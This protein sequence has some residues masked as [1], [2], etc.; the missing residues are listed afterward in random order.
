MMTGISLV[1]SSV[2]KK[3]KN[4][5]NV[6]YANI[7]YSSVSGVEYNKAYVIFV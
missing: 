5:L 7:H 1:F 3:N 4:K 6:S 2:S